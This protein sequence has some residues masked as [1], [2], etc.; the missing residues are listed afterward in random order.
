[1][2]IDLSGKVAVVTGSSRGI[3]RACAVELGRSGADVV[4]NYHTHAD[5]GESA[6]AEIRGFGRRAVAVGADVS[7]RGGCEKLMGA[8]ADQFGRLD[9]LV[10]NA[11]RSVRKPVVDLTPEDVA[12]TWDS[13]LWQCFHTSQLAARQM[14]AQGEG[15]RI[16]FISSVHA[17]AAYPTAMP[18]NTAKAGINH[19]ARTLAAELAQDLILV[20]S[21]EPGWID[22]PGERNFSTEE[23]LLEAGKGVP[24]GRLGK[25]EEIGWLVV[26]LASDKASYITGS[27]LRA[28]GGY[29]LPRVLEA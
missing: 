9:I 19:M 17:S 14:L 4:V 22:T 10:A 11:Y 21:V 26:F 29:V 13:V 27:V 18:Y 15:G 8:A 2:Q 7:T 6:A 23:S 16:I 20:N 1:M 12:V 24:V 5:E 25:P 28:D 3:G